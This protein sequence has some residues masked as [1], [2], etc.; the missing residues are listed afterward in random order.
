MFSWERF[1]DVFP[2]IIMKFPVT[3]E[4]VLVSFISGLV[5]GSLLAL[6]RIKNIPVLSQLVAVYISYIR[7][8]P[9]ICQMFV[10]YFGAPA[11]LGVLGIDTSGIERIV[12]LHIAYGM[13]NGGF[14][15]ETI[16]ASIQAVPAGQTE[17][18]R[19]V[20]LKEY[21]TLLHIVGPQA[22]RIALPMLGT[23]FVYSFQSTA[24]AYMVGVIDMI[25]RARALGTLSGHTLEGYICCALVFVVISLVLEFA[26]NKMNKHLDFGKS[27][28]SDFKRKAVDP[29]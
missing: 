21:Q 8:T 23:L 10:V 29:I 25:G 14:M 9:V 4:I 7:C 18:G 19:A 12:Y 13:N 16:R 1:F 17:A 3:L 27:G 28:I 5:L 6:I 2:E 22:V 24:L 20:G 15:G 11:L 26:F